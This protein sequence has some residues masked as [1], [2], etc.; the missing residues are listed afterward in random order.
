MPYEPEYPGPLI[1]YTWAPKNKAH[2][3]R[4]I[5]GMQSPT[6]ANSTGVPI[7]LKKINE[8]KVK[9]DI[10]NDDIKRAH[11]AHTEQPKESEYDPHGTGYGGRKKRRTKRKSRKSRKPKKSKKKKK[12]KSKRTQRTHK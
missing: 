10:D 12:K 3:T 7:Y 5:L 8:Y 2:A 6:F 4:R 9:Y 1:S 11:K